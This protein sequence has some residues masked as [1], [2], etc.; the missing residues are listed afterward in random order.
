MKFNAS[1]WS[2]TTYFTSPAEHN[3][4][5]LRVTVAPLGS[6]QFNPIAPPSQEEANG[7]AAFP[8]ADC[9]PFD[10]LTVAW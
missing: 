6:A 10:A 1:P 3:M 9:T 2:C 5:V 8:Y 7:K 4:T